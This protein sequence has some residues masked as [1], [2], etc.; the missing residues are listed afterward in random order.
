MFVKFLTLY[1]NMISHIFFFTILWSIIHVYNS[2]QSIYVHLFPCHEIT[3]N[4]VLWKNVVIFCM[5]IFYFIMYICIAT[6]MYIL[7]HS[8]KFISSKS[9]LHVS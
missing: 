6:N 5:D 3:Y 9:C 8:V 1:T 7:Y 2:H 4:I